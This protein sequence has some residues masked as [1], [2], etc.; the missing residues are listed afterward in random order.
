MSS[1]FETNQLVARR[2]YFEGHGGV[3]L[4]GDAFGDPM[5]PPVILLP[6][7]GQT[8]HAWGT[9]AERLAAQGWYALALDLR[10]HGDSS[11]ASDGDYSLT[12]FVGDL[13]RVTETLRRAPVIVGASLGG[14]TGLLAAGET[15]PQ[16][17][18]AL[19]LVDIAPRMESDGVE[20]IVGFMRA[21]L[22]GFDSLEAAADA[23]TEYLPRRPRPKDLSGLTKNLRLGEDRRYRWHWDPA[24]VLGSKRPSGSQQP[25]RLLAA[26]R[27]LTIPALLVRGQMSE[28]ISEAGARE[29]LEAVPHA[30]YVDVSD[31][32]HMVA[33]D[34][35]DV[36]AQAV[37]DFL[38]A[39]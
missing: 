38:R 22:D 17:F 34:R 32:G 12:A 14:I 29:F 28:V 4:A 33:G 30:R 3:T 8:R 1:R 27:R 2:V 6:G 9:A 39:L 25:E 35:N 18:A 7:G 16:A 20:R 15:A 26:A 13:L 19:V 24:F 21:H 31:A 11:W 36:F 37:I 10:G 5:S 23:I